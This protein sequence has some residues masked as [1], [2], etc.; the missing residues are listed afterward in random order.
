M[1]ALAEFVMKG[2]AQAVLVAVFATGSV[3]FAW[4]G[5]AVVA[6]VT[7]RKGPAQGAQVLFWTMVP[8]LVLAA[9][10]DTGPVTT[11]L[12]VMLAATVLRQ[13]AS[14]SWTLLAA[15]VS[16]VVTTIL[17]AT[18]GQGYIAEIL[19]L[20]TEAVTQ[21]ASQSNQPTGLH[22]AIPSAT[23]VA[24][25]L[26]LSNGFIVIISLILARW[27]QSL[28]YN[29]A[30]FGTEFRALRLT[31][32]LTTLLLVA[33][34]GVSALGPDYRLWGLIFALPLLFAGLALIHD[35]VARRQ[36]N[37]NWLIVFYISFLLLDP[38]KLVLL[39]AAIL[40]SWFNIRARVA[41]R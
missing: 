32:Q 23:Q 24:G 29:P 37:S 22:A 4:V 28:L 40:D 34:F 25:L 8:G 35:L 11:L 31:P 7:L 6:L 9:M 5:A 18:I 27:W 41:S 38:V 2:R 14:W 16:A 19:R 36:L 13:F 10:G 1:R 39:V 17:M 15:V 21:I 30:G 12:G 3:L 26:G 33:G 20:L